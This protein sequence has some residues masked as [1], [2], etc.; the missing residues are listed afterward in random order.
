MTCFSSFNSY[1]PLLVIIISYS[2]FNRGKDR[3]RKLK[4][5][6]T[7][8][9]GWGHSHDWNPGQSGCK[10]QQLGHHSAG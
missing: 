8:Q 4:S 10:V 2:L 6:K 3:L 5:V 1:M 7:K 9:A